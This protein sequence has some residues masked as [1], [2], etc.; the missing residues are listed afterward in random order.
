MPESVAGWTANAPVDRWP[1][2]S[3]IGQRHPKSTQPPNT[4]PADSVGETPAWPDLI[5]DLKAS[6]PMHCHSKRTIGD[7]VSRA[8]TNPGV[9]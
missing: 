1:S 8:L 7:L 5:P 6:L 2:S 4:L 3:R 9:R